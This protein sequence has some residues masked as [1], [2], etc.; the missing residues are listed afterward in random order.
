METPLE[1]NGQQ[2][3]ESLDAVAQTMTRTKR[4]L[5]AYYAGPLLIL[6]GILFI[7]AYAVCHFYV[8][9]AFWIF[10]VMN[11][12]GGAGTAGIIWRERTHAPTHVQSANPLGKKV[13]WFWFFLFVYLSIWL[14]LLSPFHGRQLNAVIVTTVMFAYVVMGLLY[15]CQYL[16]IVGLF[17]TAVTLLAYYAFGDWYCLLLAV[18]G[19]GALF[20]TGL[21]MRLKWK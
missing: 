3:R 10:M 20:G 2:A 21:Y 5:E 17:V 6:W 1:V 14:N 7:A 4:S 16:T 12:L 11:V 18:F 9:H 19:G 15:A 8:Q 13:F